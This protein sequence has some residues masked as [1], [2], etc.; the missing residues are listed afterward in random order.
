MH[1]VIMPAAMQVTRTVSS[2]LEDM[3]KKCELATRQSIQAR[4]QESRSKGDMLMI[5]KAQ[6]S[7]M[8]EIKQ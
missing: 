2:V 4:N 6:E 1:N 5:K 8:T 7:K 3:K